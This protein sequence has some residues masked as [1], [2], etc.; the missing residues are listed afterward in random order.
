MGYRREPIEYE[1]WY[2]CFNRGIDRRSVFE[3]EDDCGRFLQL[4]YLAND[5]APIKRQ[6]IGHLPLDEILS[7]SREASVVAIGA[8]ALMSNHFHI[9]L[10]EKTQGGISRFMHK[11]AT[12][13]TMYFNERHGRIGNLFIKPFRSKRVNT[14]RYLR[15]VAQYIHLNAAE[16]FEPYWK[17]GRVTNMAALEK[18]LV[19]YPYSSLPDYLRIQRRQKTI[20][21][22][23]AFDLIGDRLPT[24]STVLSDAREYYVE[25]EQEY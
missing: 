4:L 9:L 8:Y 7:R 23:E 21:D 2:H 1:Q 24:L 18:N 10:R 17:K 25:A 3:S 6:N 15:C 22:P 5:T 16:R 20:L 12:G 13:Y 11:V 19:A 14:D